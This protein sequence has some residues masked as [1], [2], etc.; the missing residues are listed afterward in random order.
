MLLDPLKK[1]RVFNTFNTFKILHYFQVD[2]SNSFGLIPP[3]QYR[4]VSAL[5]TSNNIR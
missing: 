3:W 5:Y 1:L 4:L 2:D